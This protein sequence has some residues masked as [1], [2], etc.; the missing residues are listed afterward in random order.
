MLPLRRSARKVARWLLVTIRTARIRFRQP[1]AAIVPTPDLKPHVA[2][3][4]RVS[5]FDA[6]RA[7]DLLRLQ[8]ECG[9]RVPGTSTHDD[10]FR[11]IG[12]ELAKWVDQ[13]A[14]QSWMQRVERGA[15]AGR[16]FPMRNLFGLIRGTCDEGI[17]IDRIQ[18]EVMLCAHWDTR[19]IAEHDPDPSRRSDPIPGANDGASGVAVLL[20]VARALHI[21]PPAISVLLAFWDGEDLGEY[22]YGSRVYTKVCDEPAHARWR[23]RRAILLDMVGGAGLRCTSELHSMEYAKP[24]WENVHRVARAMGLEGHFGGPPRRINDDHVFLNRAGIPAIVLIDYSYPFWHS[25]ADDVD[26]CSAESLG[27]VGSVLLRYLET[28][29][30]RA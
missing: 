9:P 11:L 4:I 19:P 27:V 13:I 21:R 8:C 18:P 23:P 26:K 2:S 7:F 3:P 29:E 5:A 28:A 20:E 16:S 10:A 30:S 25:T 24:L 6:E 12:G 22:Y 14:V 15:G 1:R 17:P